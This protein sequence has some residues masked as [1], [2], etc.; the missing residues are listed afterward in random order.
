MALTDAQK[1]FERA[2]GEPL[3]A[4]ITPAATRRRAMPRCT[5]T[6][7]REAVRAASR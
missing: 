2:P 5:A 3:T 4:Y 1:H 7:R 6:C